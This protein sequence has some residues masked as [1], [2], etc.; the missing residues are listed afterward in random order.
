MTLKYRNRTMC[1]SQRAMRHPWLE[2]PITDYEAHMALP[3]VGQ[4][5]LLGAALQG[6]ITQLRTGV[7]RLVARHAGSFAQFEPVLRGG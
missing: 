2:I 3:S 7:R 6:T 1:F 5:Q 4:A